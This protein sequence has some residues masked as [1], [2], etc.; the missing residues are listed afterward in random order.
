MWPTVTSDRPPTVGG[1]PV[2]AV[3]RA[4]RRMRPY[5]GATLGWPRSLWARRWG[6]LRLALAVGLL[7]VF[8]GDN[9]ARLARLGYAALPDLDHLAEARRLTAA[10]QYD[11]ALL[12]LDAGIVDGGDGGGRRAELEAA[13]RE[14]LARRDSIW[15]RAREAGVGALTGTGTSLE[16]LGG[17]LLA[18]LIVAGDVRDLAIQGA[19]LAL[20]GETDEI[21]VVLSGLGLVTTLNPS[22]DIVPGFLK[23]AHK[24]G[25]VTRRL[26]RGLAD[27]CRTA[28][29][30]RRY[31]RL[32]A[33]AGSLRDLIGRTTPR[34]AARVLKACDDPKEVERVAE[35]AARE[36]GAGLAL[37]VLGEDAVALAGR[38]GAAGDKALLLAARKGAHGAAW[39]RSGAYRLL[40][41]HPLIG[42]AKGVYKGNVAKGL[43]KL[44]DRWVD[45]G[46][47]LVIPALAAWVVA[48]LGLLVRRRAGR[49]VALAPV[50]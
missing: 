17:A 34:I 33:V 5:A 32:V 38:A 29:R 36:R 1:R 30:E 48:E 35:F 28:L 13:R 25:C 44:S 40:R 49:T 2:G 15:R 23:C 7:S 22:L 16:S 19:R 41:P 46:G 45:P 14:V 4:L 39:L 37:H 3:G 11:E 47:W 18:D 31:E 42:L 26:A 12:V 10:E 24:A 6:V 8:V 43:V 21:V 20:D 9:P 27:L 50:P